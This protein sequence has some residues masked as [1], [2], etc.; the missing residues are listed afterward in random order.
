MLTCTRNGCGQSYEETSNDAMACQYHPGRPVFHEG[1]KGWKC[2]DPRVHSFDEF[3]EIGGCKLGTHSSEPKHKDDPFKADLTKHDDVLPEP[4]KAP[5]PTTEGANAEKPQKPQA[6][7]VVDEDPVGV[8]VEPGT[9]CKR[10]GCNAVYESAERSRGAEQC[11]F[12][13]G[14]ALFH[15]GTKGWACCKP[16]ASDFE[17]FMQ[18]KGC[19]RGQHLFVG[20][21]PVKQAQTEKCR[22]DFYQLADDVVVSI[23]AKQIDREKSTVA[24]DSNTVDVHLVFGAG[25]IYNDTIQLHG[26]IDPSSSSYEFMSTKVEIRLRKADTVQWPALERDAESTQSLGQQL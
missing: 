24:I 18:I 15:E 23:Y 14:E 26:S 22:R 16:W 3:L 1:K 19:R 5:V 11:Q 6:K 4:L 13:P 25:R 8:Q 17:G 7:Y 2:C 12:H 20:T 9:K 10:N 21:Q